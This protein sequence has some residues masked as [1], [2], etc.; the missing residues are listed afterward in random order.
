MNRF[1]R[2]TRTEKH[3][4]DPPTDPLNTDTPPAPPPASE[5]KCVCEFCGCQLTPRGEVLRM[6]EAAKNFRKHEEIVERKDKEIA[7]LNRELAEVKQERDALK[8]SSGGG[9]STG[10]RPGSRIQ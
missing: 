5:R 7:N 4:P 3:R 9:T 6:G 8:A 10:H 2:N 1:W